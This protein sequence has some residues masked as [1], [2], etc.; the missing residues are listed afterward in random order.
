MQ[1]LEV[2]EAV[3]LYIGRTVSKGIYCAFVGLNNKLYTMRA[4]YIKILTI[5]SHYK[6]I[7]Q[8]VGKT[9]QPKD[10]Q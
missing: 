8:K 7:T 4:T 3:V 10:L 5:R 6:R 9:A 2:S 1:H